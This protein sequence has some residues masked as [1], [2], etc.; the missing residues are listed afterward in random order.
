MDKRQIVENEYKELTKLI[1]SAVN[2]LDTSNVLNRQSKTLK[3]KL[4]EA[5]K[6]KLC[7]VQNTMDHSLNVMHWDKLVIAFF[8]ATNAGKSTIIETFRILFDS[9]RPQAS[10][11]NI[12][13]D[14]QLDYTKDYHEYDLTIDG[15]PFVLI[16]VPGIEG[17]EAE[18]KDGIKKALGQSHCIF[19][20]HG[21]N[22][23]L[24]PPII[25]KI[26]SYLGDWV[27]VYSI[28]NVRGGVNNYDEPE[29]RETLFSDSTLK[30]EREIKNAFHQTL[31]EV[32]KGN[33][34][35][36]ALLAMC[37]KASFAPER[38]GLSKKQKSLLEYFGSAD[39][40]LRFSQFQTLINQ[41]EQKAKNFT[42]E[43][44]SANILK[45]R[46]LKNEILKEL[47]LIC[48][49]V[50]IELYRSQL[51]QFESDM[52]EIADELHSKLKF[53]IDTLIKQKFD[54]IVS[55]VNGILAEKSKNKKE[56]LDKCVLCLSDEIQSGMQTI[57]DG[58]AQSWNDF[59][60]RKS[61]NFDGFEDVF[62]TFPRLQKKSGLKIDF[63][64]AL[65][66]L[67]MNLGD[68]RDFFA[69]VGI[70]ALGGAR[71]GIVGAIGGAVL[72]GASCVGQKCAFGDG[73]VGC[74][75][76][77]AK[78]EI[79]YEKDRLKRQLTKL[80][81]NLQKRV[82]NKYNEIEEMIRKELQSV[83][84]IVSIVSDLK[85]KFR[86]VCFAYKQG[87]QNGRI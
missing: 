82:S 56:Q 74:A 64:D 24:E 67:E 13:G 84:E 72:G 75:Q 32:Y 39:E 83:E 54:T 35:L 85:I 7:C 60:E 1:E 16:D 70:G 36:Q 22:K 2:K 20:V 3:S 57:M 19:Y 34:T 52:K 69:R 59:V 5:L 62:L 45:V 55:M 51:K 46:S 41:V 8:G 80:V 10:D 79:A 86:R 18:F 81:E 15:L 53:Q 12:V 78:C 40:I 33:I 26:Q 66:K 77:V 43:I 63:S 47:D 48:S 28:Y 6:E 44:S 73:G 25:K 50:G 87:V 30:I 9:K 11:G 58:C 29:E 4:L 49:E 38:G 21:Q 68:V 14:G 27:Q 23:P 42:D 65:E 37:A 31:G 71:A 61:S 17:E 76:D